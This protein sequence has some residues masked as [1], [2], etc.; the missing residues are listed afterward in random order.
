M[1]CQLVNLHCAVINSCAIF[2]TGDHINNDS[3]DFLLELPTKFALFVSSLNR[4]AQCWLLLGRVL[5]PLSE[6]G[7]NLRS[8]LPLTF[9]DVNA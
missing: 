3:V 9:A 2:L 1:P 4:F 7:A 8:D 6:L 5:F